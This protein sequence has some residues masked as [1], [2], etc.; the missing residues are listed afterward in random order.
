MVNSFIRYSPYLTSDY[1]KKR[2]KVVT[3]MFIKVCQGHHK[4]YD[5]KSKRLYFFS[6]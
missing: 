1:K 3:S 2:A 4:H 6:F 5:K